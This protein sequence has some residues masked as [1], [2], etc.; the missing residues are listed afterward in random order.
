MTA[1][2]KNKNSNFKVPLI[3][4]FKILLSKK[5]KIDVKLIKFEYFRGKNM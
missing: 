2:Y 4:H 1:I 3:N 5:Q